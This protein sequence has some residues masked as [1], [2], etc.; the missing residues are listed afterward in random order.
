MSED[1]TTSTESTLVGSGAEPAPDTTSSPGSTAP[2]FTYDDVRK[3]F[4]E[5]IRGDKVFDQIKTVEDLGKSFLHAQ[6]LVGKKREDL[7]NS[8]DSGD[9]EALYKALGR[10]DAADGYALSEDIFKD[11]PGYDPEYVK[12]F[13]EVSHRL[14]LS[15]DQVEGLVNFQVDQINGTMIQLNKNKNMATKELQDLWGGAYEKNLAL[16]QRAAE[17]L[18]L[19]DYLNQTGLGNEP[20]LVRAFSRMGQMMVENNLIEPD[21]EGIPSKENVLQEALQIRSDS[22]H[23]LHKAYHDPH[24]PRHDEAVGKVNRMYQSAFDSPF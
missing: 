1:Q 12:Q 15:K 8:Q 14:G 16:G 17:T 9:R 13:S 18:G 3:Q 23:P 10:P 20:R 22:N 11:V 7:L 21:T 4:P 2:E 6:K 5:D 19:K 24:D